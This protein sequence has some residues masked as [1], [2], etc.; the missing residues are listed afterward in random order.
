MN[1]TLASAMM[2]RRGGQ[3]KLAR[4]N[5][6]HGMPFAEPAAAERRLSTDH[7]RYRTL[8]VGTAVKVIQQTAPT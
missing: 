5:G 2:R 3:G 7:E 1:A 6:L 8:E 4:K